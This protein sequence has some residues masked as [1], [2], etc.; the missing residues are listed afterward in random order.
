MKHLGGC[1]N[2]S[3]YLLNQKAW[4]QTSVTALRIPKKTGGLGHRG[5]AFLDFLTKGEA[6]AVKVFGVFSVLSC[7]NMLNNHVCGCYGRGC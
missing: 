2:N 1:S 3:H 7:V 4:A 6:L 5:F